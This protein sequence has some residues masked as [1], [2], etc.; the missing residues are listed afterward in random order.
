MNAKNQW[1]LRLAV[2]LIGLAMLLSTGLRRGW[3][4]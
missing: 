2:S 1:L 4:R 3:I